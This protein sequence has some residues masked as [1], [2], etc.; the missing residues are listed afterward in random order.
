MAKSNKEWTALFLSII[1]VVISL[2]SCIVSFHTFSLH[3]KEFTSDRTMLLTA[4][5][6]KNIDGKITFN[7]FNQELKP[8]PRLKLKPSS[9]NIKVLRLEL[10]YP[11]KMSENDL[12]FS[13]QSSF[14]LLN[15]ENWINLEPVVTLIKKF[16]SETPLPENSNGVDSE[17]MVIVKST[18]V[19]RNRQ[20]QQVSFYKIRYF[21]VM[22]NNSE[23]NEPLSFIVFHGFEWVSDVNSDLFNDSLDKA[24]NGEIFILS[25]PHRVG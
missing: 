8:S 10:F 2:I 17:V 20:F 25:Y 21:I 22:Y 13:K 4:Q 15:T 9:D 14:V 18:Y 23:N 16:H 1:A 5:F 24:K 12:E 6:E 19:V 11:S 3:Q 7:Y